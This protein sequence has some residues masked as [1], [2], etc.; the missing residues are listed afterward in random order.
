VVAYNAAIRF[1]QGEVPWVYLYGPP[2]NGKTHLAAAA[3]NRLIAQRRAVLF[4]TAPELL[5]M[6][7]IAEV[8]SGSGESAWTQRLF[9]ENAF[10]PDEVWITSVMT[11]WWEST[12]DVA[13]LC[14][15]VFPSVR[16]RIS[17]IYPTLASAHLQGKLSEPWVLTPFGF[18]P[19]VLHHHGMAQTGF[20][21]FG[22][23][24]FDSRTITAPS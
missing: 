18:G 11:Y 9:P 19:T 5:V 13:A 14:K 1:V 10:T 20:H 17:G 6:A 8:V 15:E 23:E 22:N 16:I 4:T 2:G 12:V 24:L 3:V 7:G 21:Q